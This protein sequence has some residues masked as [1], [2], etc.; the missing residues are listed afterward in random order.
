MA[1][2]FL[3]Y[4]TFFFAGNVAVQPNLL[5]RLLGFNTFGAFFYFTELFFVVS[6]TFLKHIKSHNTHCLTAS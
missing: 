3:L 2:S 6:F 4:F 5:Q 1:L